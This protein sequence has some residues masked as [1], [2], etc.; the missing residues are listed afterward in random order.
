MIYIGF[1]SFGMD[2]GSI[3]LFVGLIALLLD[4]FIVL[5]GEYIEKWES[6]SELCLTVGIA[7]IIISFGYFSYSVISVDYSFS[8]VSGYVNNDMDFFLRLSAIW[9]GAVGSYFFWLFLVAL[10]Y[11]IFRNMFRKHAHEP[12]LWKSFVMT[13]FQVVALTALTLF[14]DPFKLNIRTV[15]DGVGLTPILLTEWNLIHPP[16]IF[17]GYALCLVPM[18]IGI[19]RIS[20]LKD[21][22]V[23][24]FVGK[25]KLDNF[26]E[27]IVSLAWL[28]LS[29]GII[30]GG[31]WAYITL[32]WGGFWAWDPVETASLV[33][34]FFITLYYHGKPFLGKREYLGNYLVSMSYFGTLFATYLTRSSIILSVHTFQPKGTLENIL[35]FFIPANSFIMKIILRFIPDEWLLFLFIILFMTFIIPLYYGIK[36]REIFRVPISLGRKDFTA[37]RSRITALK[38]SFI[39]GFLCV[40]IIIIGLLAP[41][42]YDIIGYLITFSPDGFG[43]SI[44]IG[45]LFFNTVITIF[46]GV[47]LLAQFFCNF[48]PRLS[49]K[50]KF[51]L[52]IGGVIAGITFSVGGFFY[53][54]GSLN[55]ILGE[56][57]PILVF[58]NNFWTTSDK[59]NLVI[60]LLLLGIVGLI[61]EFITVSLKEE[62]NLIRKTSQ[63][64]LHFSFLVILLGALL[65]V[66]MTVSNDTPPLPDGAVYAIP[67][68][69]IEITILELVSEYPTTGPLHVEYTTQFMLSSGARVIGFGISTLARH[70]RWINPSDESSGYNAKVT[71]ISDLLYDIYIVAAALPIENPLIGFTHSYL[72]IKIVPYISILWAGCLFLHFAMIPLIIGRFVIVK[73]TY[74]PVKKEIDKNDTKIDTSDKENAGNGD[75]PNG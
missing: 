20:S 38:I 53:R 69:S 3:V 24:E 11:M 47:M 10:L 6:F 18:A 56:N 31:Y 33:P 49:L 27:F 34:W 19:A 58:F 73:K 55:Q 22:K 7:A 32:G 25:E 61:V 66:N 8:Y 13:N 40:Y 1:G 57:N 63:I 4:V 64:M 75:K 74:S 71:I 21:G 68:T 45:Q 70:K 30:I 51:S 43:S 35:K 54:N 15:T 48:Y 14:N 42:F 52:L 9:S 5:S 41:V 12:V 59:A 16:I 2:L 17:I 26:F 44:D 50:K 62:K 60:P 37:S 72:R 65:S 23:P 36:S 29:S 67:G 39:S 28:L 46:G